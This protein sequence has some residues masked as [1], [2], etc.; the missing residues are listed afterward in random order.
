M[1]TYEQAIL[2]A[3]ALDS[4]KGLDIQVPHNYYPEDDPDKKPTLQW[5]AHA[6]TLY[7]NW[8]NYYVYQLTPYIWE[9]DK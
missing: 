7:T 4:K 8:L 1:N 3:K 5:R 2:T 9:D 6:N